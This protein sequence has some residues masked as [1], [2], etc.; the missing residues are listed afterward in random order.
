M[1]CSR[2]KF[3]KLIISVALKW[4]WNGKCRGKVSFPVFS[5]KSETSNKSAC[6]IVFPTTDGLRAKMFYHDNVLTINPRTPPSTPHQHETTRRGA[7]RR[8]PLALCVISYPTLTLHTDNY[9]KR[10]RILRPEPGLY[11]SVTLYFLYFLHSIEAFRLGEKRKSTRVINL[12]VL[13]EKRV[14]LRFKFHTSPESFLTIKD[15]L[16]V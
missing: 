14:E 12:Y 5:G 11:I 2:N 7:T 15:G 9:V 3:T 6:R 10:F 13:E 16:R 4:P 1:N 8:L